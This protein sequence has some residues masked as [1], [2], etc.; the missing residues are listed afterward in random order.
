MLKIF[1]LEANPYFTMYLNG[2]HTE[3]AD[4]I[5]SHPDFTNL[6]IIAATEAGNKSAELLE[7][8]LV[9]MFE[10]LKQKYQYIFINTPPLL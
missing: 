5:Q 1:D 10:E 6:D 2:D 9:P 8:E 4:A 7:K 3:I